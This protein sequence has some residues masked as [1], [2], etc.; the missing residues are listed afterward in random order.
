VIE[1]DRGDVRM[2]SEILDAVVE[3]VHIALL[4]HVAIA[5]EFDRR[6][7]DF[8]QRQRAVFRE[9]GI[10]AHN[11]ARHADA[12]IRIGAPIRN[13]VTLR[14][15]EHRR[16]RSQRRFLAEV[17][18]QIATILEMHRDETAAADVAAA[19]MHHCFRIADGD[20]GIDGVATL[21]QHFDA[22]HR[23]VM[24]RTDHHAVMAGDRFG[25]GE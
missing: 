13:D 2:L 20:G 9:R 12:Q 18:E 4:E 7:D 10:E 24:L 6:R 25:F 11:G 23:R 21:L 1:E 17:E 22:G 5:R 3:N 14:I 19:R 8:L 16:R 15:L